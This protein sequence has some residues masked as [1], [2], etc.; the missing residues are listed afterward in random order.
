VSLCR[1]KA[2]WRLP[3]WQ[4]Q[5]AAGTLML[6]LILMTVMSNRDYRTEVALW[7]STVQFA[8]GKARPHHNLGC[9]Y[10]FAG[11]YE[12]A[13]REYQAALRLRPDYDLARRSHT[14][15]SF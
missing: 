3:R 15:I 8:P 10:V 6:A 7:E 1:L 9:A 14:E 13:K 11:R 4:A 12:E 5:L 2:F